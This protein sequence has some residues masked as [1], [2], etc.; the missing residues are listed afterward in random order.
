MFECNFCGTSFGTNVIELALH[1]GR[2]HDSPRSNQTT[3]YISL[4]K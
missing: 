4:K 2:I 1:I 3:N